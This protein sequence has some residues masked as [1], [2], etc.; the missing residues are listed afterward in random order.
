MSERLAAE[1]FAGIGLVR[2]ALERCGW[3]VVFANDI[4]PGKFQMYRACFGAG[5]FAL[6][7]IR[8]I[9]AP[10][11]PTVQ[12]ATASF[13]CVDLS[14]AGNR[15]GLS[16]NH[17][18]A[19]WEFHRILKEMGGRRPGTVLLENV[20]GLLTSHQGEDLRSLITSLSRLGYWC[21]L[22]LVDAAH[23]T[24]QSRPRLFIVGCQSPAGRSLGEVPLDDARPPQVVRFIHDNPDLQWAFAPLPPLPPK[25]RTLDRVL[26]RLP[27]AA[28]EWWED[29]RKA[30]LFRQMS[31]AHKRTLRLLSESRTYKFA[32]VYK[33]VRPSGCRAEIRADGLAGCLR[34]PRGGSSKQFVIQAGRGEWRVRNMTAREYARLQGAPDHFPIEVPYNQALFGFGDAVCVPVVEW[35]LRH[36]IMDVGQ[37]NGGPGPNYQVPALFGSGF[38][39]QAQALVGTPAE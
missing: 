3:R 5:D 11:V 4:D 32:T 25:Q 33:R 30:H 31:A 39:G 21:D 38:A 29:E 19:Y 13:P 1:F 20:A 2:L 28:A 17:S 36:A 6:G 9:S 12:L 14:L 22:L 34:T 15:D 8:S 18:S 35:V 23:M 10:M 7:D 24:P 27:P 26:E 37:E 16:G